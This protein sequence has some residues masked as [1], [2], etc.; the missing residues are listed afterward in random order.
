MSYKVILED[1]FIAAIS[2]QTSSTQKQKIS[3]FQRFNT[4]PF[5]LYPKRC[6]SPIWAKN[7]E[8]TRQMAAL[9]H[10]LL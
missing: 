3:K 6:S 2:I 1:P 8:F 5:I 9:L 7:V 10:R 4:I